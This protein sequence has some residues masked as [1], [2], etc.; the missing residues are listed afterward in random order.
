MVLQVA[1]PS[2]RS[3]VMR[4]SDRSLLEIKPFQFSIC[5]PFFLLP[6]LLD[7]TIE[8]GSNVTVFTEY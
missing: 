4:C 3:K 7:S 5:T 6:M 8:L 2:G 1:F